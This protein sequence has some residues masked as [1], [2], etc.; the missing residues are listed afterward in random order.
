LGEDPGQT[1]GLENGSYRVDVGGAPNGVYF[2]FFPRSGGWPFSGGYAQ[3]YVE[4][5]SWD[6][7]VNRLRFW[8]KSSKSI[9]RRSD[10]GGLIEIGTYVRGHSVTDVSWAGDHYYHELDP[11]FYSG[12]WMLVEINRVPQ[13][14]VG[15]DSNFNWPE[16][17]EYS[18]QLT[19]GATGQICGT[20][21][22][23]YF[24]GLTRFYF[25]SQGSQFSNST[26]WFSDFEFAKVDGEPETLVSSLTATYTGTSYEVTW[27]GPKNVS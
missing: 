12:R 26:W 5:G 11:S 25:D 24:D 4:S 7:N 6:P 13:H 3:Q 27:S 19:C 9:A 16:D 8:V 23:H 1:G 10:G 20:Q 15:S 14:Q 2:H 21:N 18:P 22:V 17:P